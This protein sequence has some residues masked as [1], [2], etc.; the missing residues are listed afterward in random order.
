M[1]A[2]VLS[3][4]D[5]ANDGARYL[6]HIAKWS[7]VLTDSETH[8]FSPHPASPVPIVTPACS[9]WCQPSVVYMSTGAC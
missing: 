6:G 7:E 5:Y 2:V 9:K 8:H 3:D 4:F 1:S